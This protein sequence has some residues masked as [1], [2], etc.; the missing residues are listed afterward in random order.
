[1]VSKF[2]WK[3]FNPR[4]ALHWSKKSS[5][6]WEV[7]VI[8]FFLIIDLD[9]ENSFRT[10]WSF[11]VV[12]AI[13]G[14]IY[15]SLQ[16]SEKFSNSPLSTVVE[17]TIFP[18]AEIAYPAITICNKNRFHKQRCEEA[19]KKFL[20]KSDNETLDVFRHLI[21]SLN[22]LEFGS[23]VKRSTWIDKHVNTSFRSWDEFDQEIFNFTSPEMDK[24]N[25]TEIFEFVMLKCEEIYVGRC[26]WRNKY[27]NCCSDIF[28]IQ[29]TEYGLC[30]TFNSAVSVVGK[31]KAVKKKFVLM[32]IFWLNY[33]KDNESVHYPFRTSNYGDW[34]GLRI[35]LSS[36]SDLSL[37]EAIDGVIVIVQHPEQWPNSGYFIPSSSQ[38]T[39]AIKPT[40][41]YTTADVRRLT[42]EE[43]QCLNV[44]GNKCRH[45]K[46]LWII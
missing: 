12:T 22:L 35:E 9:R 45:V 15:I 8:W 14:I 7:T 41:S 42:P 2:L 38:T 13:F 19:E 44:S 11:L 26:W 37:R 20:A 29:R 39:I 27:M 23:V 36:R 6:D 32:N 18:V 4:C 24:L 31:K 1:M 17:S 25:L 34:S 10:I 28:E 33:F 3:Y 46:V 40:Y 21:S 43:R 5:L 30:Y 16:L